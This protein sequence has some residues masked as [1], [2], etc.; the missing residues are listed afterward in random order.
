MLKN[1]SYR[2]ALIGLVALVMVGC[3]DSAIS[4]LQCE[5]N[6][7][8][9]CES[10]DQCQDTKECP[11][12]QD[13][14]GQ[15]EPS[16]TEKKACA[17]Q[18]C[19]PGE[20]KCDDV[21]V[22]T[23]EADENGCGKWGEPTLCPDK[24]YCREQ[25]QKCQYACGDECDPFTLVMIPDTQYYT[26]STCPMNYTSDETD[27]PM[28]AYEMQ[29]K[30]I[31][32]HAK[33]LN[34]KM[35]MHLGDMTN[36]NYDSQW[37][38]A[39]KAHKQLDIANVPYTVSTGNHDYDSYDST[40]RNRTHF[41]EYFNNE[42]FSGKD[43][44]H[45]YV[46]GANSYATFEVGDI[47]FL[48]IA[49][50]FGPRKDVLCWANDV[51]ANHKDRYVIITSHG[52]LSHK[53]GVTDV[54][55]YETIENYETQ[56]CG[57]SYLPFTYFGGAGAPIFDELARRHS[58]VILTVSGHV[59]D[60]EFRVRE[61][62]NGNKVSEML[63]DYQTERHCTQSPCD[64][65]CAHSGDDT[66]NGW[67]RLVTFDPKQLDP[68]VNNV[69][70]RSVTS[71]ATAKNADG[72]PYFADNIQQF[73]C[74]ELLAPENI[75]D[76]NERSNH[77]P[78]S[79]ESPIHRPS[80]S[81]NMLDPIDYKY[82]T[83]GFDAFMERDV[84][85]LLGGVQELP[86]VA[87]NPET[88]AFVVVWQDDYYTPDDVINEDGS[89]VLN[90]DIEAR[91]FYGGGCAKSAQF[92]I[93]NTRKGEQSTPDVAMDKNGNFAVVWADDADGNGFF[94]INMRTF[95]ANGTPYNKGIAVNTVAS[96]Q[97]FN[98]AVSMSPDGD[99][100]VVWED[101]SDTNAA[102]ELKD[103]RPQIY[104]RGF[105]VDG[106]ERFP[107]FNVSSQEDGSFKNFNTVPKVAVAKDGAFVVTW[108]VR[109]EPEDV[110]ID[111][112]TT[113]PDIKVKSFNSDGSVRTQEVV[114]NSVTKGPQMQPSVAVNAKG[115]YFVAY[116]DDADIN[117]Y[118]RVKAVG[119]SADG[120]I[121]R[122]DHF[123][124]GEGEDAVTS[125]VC[126]LDDGRA[127][128]TWNA[129]AKSE[130]DVY[131]VDFDKDGKKGSEKRVNYQAA[132]PQ[133][134]PAIACTPDGK[135][136]IVWSDDREHSTAAD[137]YKFKTDNAS[138]I[139]VRGYDM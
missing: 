63:V 106:T 95:D 11:G 23:C 18:V 130:N 137:A 51:I 76:S 129:R 68:N 8:C 48:V 79:P 46:N 50:E 126:L 134:S 12:K 22:M 136:V 93:N 108:E 32:D 9:Q 41:M 53:A 13:K 109:P 58:N 37:Q 70:S 29:M 4:N 120:T 72:T 128:Y 118:Y 87:S 2:R 31:A 54:P 91:L 98:P 138:E 66:G 71:M 92:T 75:N 86:R 80:F 99:I 27:S 125:G 40:S 49:L 17:D 38:I 15:N 60:S 24:Q 102:K 44:F 28:G 84:N 111:I 94:E 107:Q 43:W 7:P 90:H 42:R 19:H 14:P 78:S 131:T 124:S 122:A 73:Y 57:S 47:K 6:G 113:Y 33:E 52:I 62:L 127:G 65:S 35:A 116:S 88:G 10:D 74:S 132:G 39:D 121:I 110:S 69:T 97:Q 81:L 20:T 119:Y 114:V 82:T 55:G 135:K 34:I 105:K 101:Y 117:T 25:T 36:N 89:V 59:P 64:N 85:T 115:D 26:F 139:M 96:G 100:V 3:E 77:Y 5:D 123:V 133:Q 103:K 30:W 45:G 61:G 104:A 56:Y 21:R 16:E 67:M 83:G 112:Q 1:A